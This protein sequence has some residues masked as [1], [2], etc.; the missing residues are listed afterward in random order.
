MSKK[1][2]VNLIFLALLIFLFLRLNLVKNETAGVI[3][4]EQI[5][6]VALADEPTEWIK[7]LSGRESLATNEG[8]LFL[9]PDKA[10]RSFWMKDMNFALDILWLED[11]KIIGWEANVPPPTAGAELIHYSSP[12]PVN[13]VLEVSAGTVE[14]LGLKKGDL[15]TIKYD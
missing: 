1:V 8:L 10:P 2:F 4:K 6:R 5:F 3:L 12:V 15:I 11:N 14:R 13:R 7:G 9:F